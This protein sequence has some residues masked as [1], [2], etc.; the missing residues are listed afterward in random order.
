MKVDWTGLDCLLGLLGWWEDGRDNATGASYSRQ[1][2]RVGLGC[3]MSLSLYFHRTAKAPPHSAQHRAS[4]TH[5]SLHSLY[6]R[7]ITTLR[8]SW[9]GRTRSLLV[10]SG[11]WAV[12]RKHA[13]AAHITYRYSVLG[14]LHPCLSKTL[15]A[16]ERTSMERRREAGRGGQG[17]AGALRS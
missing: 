9:L 16:N 2:S 8:M 15:F 5:Y 6:A 12:N 1:A 7:P 10:V 14:T 17:Q 13:R 3:L 11:E 4:S